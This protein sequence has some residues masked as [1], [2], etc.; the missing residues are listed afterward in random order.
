M[1]SMCSRK[2]SEIMPLGSRA[3]QLRGDDPG[4]PRGSQQVQIGVHSLPTLVRATH[5]DGGVGG[6]S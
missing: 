4:D 3:V 6:A 2:P 5:P 1:P